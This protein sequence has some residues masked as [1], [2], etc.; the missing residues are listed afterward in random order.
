MDED[1]KEVEEP[2]SRYTWPYY[3]RI[4]YTCTGFDISDSAISGNSC[5]YTFTITKDTHI[6]INWQVDYALDVVSLVEQATQEDPLLQD[7][8]LRMLGNPLYNVDNMS[9]ANLIVGAARPYENEKEWEWGRVWIPKG[10]MVEIDVGRTGFQPELPKIDERYVV[11]RFDGQ[12]SVPS[13]KEDFETSPTFSISSFVMNEPGK[14][15]LRWKKQ[16]SIKLGP[17]L[18][19]EARAYPFVDIIHG[20]RGGPNQ[21][22]TLYVQNVVNAVAITPDRKYTIYGSDNNL[23]VMDIPSRKRIHE[24]KGHTNLV[25]AVAVTLD[26]KYAISASKDHTLKIWNIQT[27]EMLHTLEGHTDFVNAVSLFPDGTKAISA[28]ADKTLIVWNLL[29]GTIIKSLQH[30]GDPK[31]VSVTSDGKTAVSCSS[32]KLYVW[33]ID[34]TTYNKL[35]PEEEDQVN[36]VAITPDGQYIISALQNRKLSVWSLQSNSN[37]KYQRMKSLEGHTGI[38]NAVAV[39]YDGKY[40][41]SAS[42]DKTLRVWTIQTGELLHPLEGHEKAVRAVAITPDGGYVISGSVDKTIKLWYEAFIQKQEDWYQPYS[43]LGQHDMPERWFDCGI[44]LFIGTAYQPGEGIKLKGWHTAGGHFTLPQGHIPSALLT[45]RDDVELRANGETKTIPGGISYGLEIPFLK[46]PTA[47]TW[48]YGDMIFKFDV[49]IGDYLDP[50]LLNLSAQGTGE[51]ITDWE[52]NEVNRDNM[53]SEINLDIEP[54]F[55]IIEGAPPG[56]SPQN[57]MVWDEV[58]KRLLPLRPGRYQVEFKAK[59]EGQSVFVEL[60]AGFF[61]AEIPNSAQQE[62]LEAREAD[63]DGTRTEEQEEM[64]DMLWL[65]SKRQQK[66]KVLKDIERDQVIGILARDLPELGDGWKQNYKKAHYRHIAGAPVVSLDPDANDKF[67]FL[68]LVYFEADTYD[69]GEYPKVQAGKAAVSEGRFT[70]GVA[71]RSVLL[72]SQSDPDNP[73]SFPA[74]GDRTQEMLFVRVVETRDAEMAKDWNHA[75]KDM[76]E[77]DTAG[78]IGTALSSD[79]D[80]TDLKTGWLYQ[81][82]TNVVGKQL[83]DPDIYDQENVEGPII[84]VNRRLQKWSKDKGYRDEI[85]V[86]WY[87]NLRKETVQGKRDVMDEPNI[88]WPWKP[89][90]YPSDKLIWPDNPDQI[91]MASRLGSAGLN[92]KGEPQLEFLSPRYTDVRIYHQPEPDKPGYNPN[93][94]HAIIADSIFKHELD[95]DGNLI[96]VTRDDASPPPAAFAFRKDLNITSEEGYTS[97]P[98]VLVEYF[99][100]GLQQHGMKVYKIEYENDSYKFSY[101]VKVGEPIDAPYPLH[102]VIGLSNM[103]DSQLG[104]KFTNSESKIPVI[105]GIYF[106]NGAENDKK[107]AAYWI[108][109]SG[110]A[111]AISGPTDYMSEPHLFGHFYYPL[112]TSFWLPT[113]KAGDKQKWLPGVPTSNGA[114]DKI[115]EGDDG[116]EVEGPGKV[117]FNTVWPE[118]LPILKIGETL[119]YP[120]GEY[121]ADN[122][123]TKLKN[124]KRADTP[125]LPGVIGWKAGQ[126]LFDSRNPTMEDD[127]TDPSNFTARL[128]NPLIKIE[129]PLRFEDMKDVDRFNPT[130]EAISLD[131]LLWRFTQLPASLQKRIYYDPQGQTAN[132]GTFITG[133]L[134]LRGYVSDRTLGDSNLT[135][136]PDPVFM[137]EPNILTSRD[138]EILEKLFES[139]NAWKMAVNDLYKRSR[140]PNRLDTS[141]ETSYLV[142]LYSAEKL[143]EDLKELNEDRKKKGLPEIKS[144]YQGSE[145]RVEAASFG[146]GLALVPNP[147]IMD[148]DNKFEEGYIALVENAHPTRPDLSPVTIHVVKLESKHRYRGNIK[149]L[150]SPNVFDEKAMLSHTGDFGGNIDNLVFDWW[151]HEAEPD[152][153]KL[154]LPTDPKGNWK[155]LTGESSNQ[156]VLEG[157][158]SLLLGDNLFFV[159]YRHK[160][161]DDSFPEFKSKTDVTKNNFPWE[162]AGAGNSPQRQP[163]GSVAY[164]PQLLMGWVKRVLDAVNPYEAR[165]STFRD[166]ESPATYASMIQ[167]AGGPYVG[168]VALNPDKDVIENVGLIQLY[169]TLLERARKLSIDLAQPAIGP[170]I[171]MALLLA[172][173][174]VSDLYMLLGNEAYADAQDPTIGIGTEDTDYGKLAPALFTFQNQEAS[175]LHEELAL[176]RGTDFTKGNPVQN[177]LFWNFFKD[178]GEA[179]YATN[180][181]IRDITG[182]DGK[183][184]GFINEY[185]AKLLYP[186]GHGD[187]WGHYLSASKAHYTLL[188]HGQFQWM[189]QAELY[190]LMDIVLNVDFLD[191]VKFARTAAAKAQTGAEI[192]NL[193]YRLA[194]TEKPEK[195]WQGLHDQK[196]GR[197]WGVSNWAKRTGQAALFDW[198]VANALLPYEAKNEEGEDKENLNKI[199]RQSVHDIRVISANHGIIQSK[200][201]EANNGLNPLGLMREAVAFDIDPVRVDRTSPQPAT[202]F[203]QIYERAVK[204]AQNAVAVWDYANELDKRLRQVEESVD[205]FYK[206]AVEQ[207]ITYRNRLIEIFGLP[208]EGTI[209][210][211]QPYPEGYVGPDTM[212]YF[213]VDQAEVLAEHLPQIPGNPGDAPA[214]GEK[215]EGFFQAYAQ[216]VKYYNDKK[217]DLKNPKDKFPFGEGDYDYEK[218]STLKGKKDPAKH[219]SDRFNSVFNNPEEN[220]SLKLP[221][222]QGPRAI[223]AAPPEWEKRKALG[224]LQEIY[225]RLMLAEL[226]YKRKLAEYQ[227]YVRSLAG[228]KEALDNAK[229]L[230][231]ALETREILNLHSN[232]TLEQSEH[233]L[234]IL[235]KEWESRAKESETIIDAA[236]TGIPAIYGF[237]NDLG[238][239]VKGT[240]KTTSQVVDASLDDASRYAKYVAW[241]VPVIKAIEDTWLKTLELKE[242]H[243]VEIEKKVQEFNSKFGDEI[244]LRLD[245]YEKLKEM[246]Q[247]GNLY[248]TTLQEGMRLLDE[249]YAYNKRLASGTQQNRYQDMTFRVMRNDALQKYRSAFDLAARYV[250]LAAMAYDYET[251]LDPDHRASAQGLLDDIIRTRTLGQWIDGEPRMGRGGLA[252]ILARLK[253]NF[254]VLN[255]Q[256]GFNNPQTEIGRL[257]LR[258]ELFRIGDDDDRGWR[259]KL[260]EN[261]VDDLWNDPNYGIYFRLHCR[262]FASPGEKQPGIVIPFETEITEGKNFFG[263]D[264]EGWDNVYDSSQYATKIRSVGVWFVDYP[265]PDLVQTPR[266]YLIPVGTD[267]M[268]I[269]DSPTLEQR[270]WNVLDQRIPVPHKIGRSDLENPNWIPASDSLSSVFSETRK[271]SRFR[272]YHDGGSETFDDSEMTWDSR[273]VG[274]SVW[275]TKWLLI[276]PGS[277]LHFDPNTGLKTLIG[278]DDSP[279]ISDIQLLFQTY[280]HSGN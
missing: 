192:T 100:T 126:I 239:P 52:G 86:V 275:N 190:N 53:P 186:Q 98:Y 200:L 207:D 115:K 47:V 136:D 51:L 185:D 111:W 211:G 123:I 73:A 201:D 197:F 118:N 105:N 199:D 26:G 93:E 215:P 61:G 108:D 163:D 260:K 242:A 3:P 145:G 37:N 46:R 43:G 20:F 119:M 203:E 151:Y 82:D 81:T 31:A 191:E 131:G 50:K 255:G 70:N 96:I 171:Q 56:S 116:K 271:F 121:R 107:Q 23:I 22:R 212:L 153:A 243:R 38:V 193:T 144:I 183:P 272:A 146:S 138:K 78:T 233:V 156:V 152:L 11:H 273:L 102:K 157:N 276:I 178:Q 84:P 141:G 124:G 45:E 9:S 173:T 58:G 76:M 181:N 30:N 74:T 24:L 246:E 224:K 62:A 160:N 208:Y 75:D 187:A 25:T 129:V 19:D 256:L 232:V 72:F 240:I 278:A 235:A 259:E 122:P 210:P 268:R 49:P 60:A 2:L 1:G 94:E 206:D 29:N 176:L 274:R 97:D 16:V 184:D 67:H 4:R 213:Y 195:R 262:P 103:N 55:T 137:L 225:G 77:S 198:A 63:T 221:F 164:I 148:P 155:K 130:S 36:D 265:N 13:N 85:V 112:L 133:K 71:G 147:A 88:N 89:V 214:E 15:V 228:I 142:G 237:S 169:R 6:N 8:E 59:K 165:F 263:K 154:P 91:V 114:P 270:R 234:K 202:H 117:R 99:D 57:T 14:L 238:A 128:V 17:I 253:D 33:N 222:I 54:T 219:P 79:Y 110:V 204:S 167:Q 87:E 134:G 182:K 5:E 236:I 44:N 218:D 209:G 231:D 120:G 220:V 10:K 32:N 257:S 247:L 149:T 42:E 244:N 65:G 170:S 90:H 132:N 125:G 172:A 28:S 254:E 135:A 68:E 175:L 217:D 251:N 280:S 101:E 140:D 159:R 162:W 258:R 180:Y 216:F 249:R 252:E 261:Q 80:R 168:P 189:A 205:Q 12:G 18:K 166:H 83:Y 161:E 230:S 69:E 66:V 269:P 113:P 150:L 27:G 194:Y 64:C 34:S 143:D 174:R 241:G 104:T 95:E 21:L 41:I 229:A 277:T 106:R 179:A 250:Y 196:E 109:S 264:V 158:P 35:E 266:V 248:L 39:T 227:Q 223:F 188:Q 127:W 279:G 92:S 226:E 177:R 139:S 48:D 40:A 245:I 7:D 267:I